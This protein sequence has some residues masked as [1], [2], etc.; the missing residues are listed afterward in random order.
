MMKLNWKKMRNTLSARE[1]DQLLRDH[2]LELKT[3]DV[4]RLRSLSQELRIENNKFIEKLEKA[5]N[6]KHH[7]LHLAFSALQKYHPEV[8]WITYAD[9]W[10]GSVDKKYWQLYWKITDYFSR[11]NLN[12][13]RYAKVNLF[14]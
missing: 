8:N 5:A 12:R 13:K 10:N 6:D 14:R 11:C 9:L 1:I 2:F 4:I 3:S 7:P